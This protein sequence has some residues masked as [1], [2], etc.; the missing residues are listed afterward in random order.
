ME[1]KDTK[2]TGKTKA[3][4]FSTTRDQCGIIIDSPNP[5]KNDSPAVQKQISGMVGA[6]ETNH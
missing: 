5:I 2:E 3:K 1:T 6:D 4:T